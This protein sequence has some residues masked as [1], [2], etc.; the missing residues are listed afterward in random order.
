[1]IYDKVIKGHFVTLRSI[2]LDDA[3]FSYNIR[4]DPRFV[5]V[6]GQAAA[7][8]EDQKKFIER[9]M[10]Q[11][12][13]YYFVVLNRLGVRIGLI[14]VYGLDGDSAETGREV[15]VGEPYETMEAEILLCDFCVNV[16]KLKTKIG[17]V[18]KH[19]KKQIELQ[20]KLGLEPCAEIVR[21]GVPA[22]EY[23][24]DFLTLQKNY[25]RARNM[26]NKLA[27]KEL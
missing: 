4:K 25:E 20:T 18:Y 1:M 15:N 10:G 22:Y 26:I 6:M 21:S 17:V 13:D 24:V 27:E 19:N 5:T 23:R 8:L 3:E 9:Q 7:T 16:L 2:T 12:G 11:P 14:G